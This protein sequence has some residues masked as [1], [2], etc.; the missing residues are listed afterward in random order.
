M[1]IAVIQASTQSAKNQ[2]LYDATK[3]AVEK[4]SEVVNFGVY[5]QDDN[6]SYVQVSIIVG[7]LISSG[8]IDFVVTGCSSGNGMNI[9][10]NAM[11]DV[12]S[13]YLPTP[14][15]AYLF[16]RI[17]YGNCASL[18]LGLNFDWA[19][20]LNLRYTLEK[21][22]DGPM[23]TGY[24]QDEA[25]RK[26]K[27]AKLVTEIKSISQTSMLEIIN[28]LDKNVLEPIWRKRDVLDY[29]IRNG[30]NSEL[31]NYLLQK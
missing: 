8:A 30:N 3:E 12:I 9:A 5:P 1:K 2:L 11:P 10:C 17:N 13:G 22:F 16:G 20:E 25:L 26:Q 14:S 23:N 24:P 15:D 29:I 7:L 27:D 6:L 4:G 18:P 19:G 31:Q 21:L 28:K